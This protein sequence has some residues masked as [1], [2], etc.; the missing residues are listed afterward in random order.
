MAT[1]SYRAFGGGPYPSL[2]EGRKSCSNRQSIRDI[3]A[4][5]ISTEGALNQPTR[6]IWSFA[7]LPGTAVLF[8]TGPGV[9]DYPADIAALGAVDLGATD[10]GFAR[11]SLRL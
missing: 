5:F 8:E 1:N 7:P 9:R 10:T 11:F 2:P 4:R 3:L 6:P